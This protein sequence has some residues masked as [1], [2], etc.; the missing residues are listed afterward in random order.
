MGTTSERS[1]T[2]MI[3]S[4]RDISIPRPSNLYDSKALQ[5]KNC[6]TDYLTSKADLIRAI[7]KCLK[8]VAEF[9]RGPQ[10]QTMFDGLSHIEGG[11]YSRQGHCLKSLQSTFRGP[12]RADIIQCSAPVVKGLVP[13]GQQDP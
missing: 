10:F 2:N 1:I 12:T 3:N 9:K 6:S 8:R 11:S 5:F 13:C 4:D 7:D